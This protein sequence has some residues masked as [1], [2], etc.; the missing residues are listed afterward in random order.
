MP[1][2]YVIKLGGSVISR[3]GD[4]VFD[5]DYL[6]NL[7]KTLEP[8][9][10]QENKFF[11]TLGGGHLMRQYRDL[12]LQAGLKQDDELHWMGI[13]VNTL[14]AQL[15]RAF[16][17]DIADKDIYQG[18]DYYSATPL[19]IENKVKLGGGGRPGTSGDKD[20]LMASIELNAKGEF[21]GSGDMDALMVAIKLKTELVISLKNI[22]AV[23]SADPKKDPNAKRLEKI[24][25]DE[26]LDIIGNPEEHAPGANYPVDPV[27]AKIAKEK[28]IA[29]QI[30]LGSDLENFAKALEGN[31]SLGTII[32]DN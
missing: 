24:T 21:W 18:D 31:K 23:Y 25:W 29:F 3:Q 14:H 7:K 12:A 26:Y 22:D 28:G 16:W 9:F 30:M 6:N 32:S 13:A 10:A 5:F 4:L 20:A 15:T 19:V 27:T 2:N 8:F 1:Q 11:I 17:H